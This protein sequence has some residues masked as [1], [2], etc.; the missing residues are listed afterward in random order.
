MRR[1]FVEEFYYALDDGNDANNTDSTCANS[2]D[3]EDDSVMTQCCV[4]IVMTKP[5]TGETDTLQRCMAE[6]IVQATWD[7]TLSTDTD[8]D[9]SEM[10]IAMQCIDSSLAAYLS[11]FG[12]LTALALLLTTSL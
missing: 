4:N 7:W 12:I 5:S 10:T 8:K 3:C 1:A 11:R 6:Q 9:N 2:T